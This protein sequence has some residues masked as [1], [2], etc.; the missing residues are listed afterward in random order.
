MIVGQTSWDVIFI[1]VPMLGIMLAAFFRLDELLVKPKRKVEHRRAIA[2]LDEKGRPICLDPD[3][4]A[5]GQVAR[6]KTRK[7]PTAI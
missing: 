6:V 4:V 5:V 3:G 2:G 7:V 1:A